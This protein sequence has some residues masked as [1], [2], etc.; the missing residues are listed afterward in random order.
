MCNIADQPD[1]CNFIVPSVVSRGDL[2]VAVST[3]GNS[4]AFARHLRQQLQKQFGPEYEPFLDLMGA[5]R[6][7]LLAAGYAPE[8]HKPLFQKLIQADLLERVKTGDRG[9]VDRLL[10]DVLGEGYNYD[11]L[12]GAE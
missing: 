9:A 5:I 10:A 6:R 3:S 1:L 12:M 11:T 4:P 8:A 7:R 2:L